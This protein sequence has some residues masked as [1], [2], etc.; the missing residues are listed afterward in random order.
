VLGA[1]AAPVY[2]PVSLLTYDQWQVVE[3]Q[4]AESDRLKRLR[5]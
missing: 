2:S 4:E 3:S 5:E 1:N